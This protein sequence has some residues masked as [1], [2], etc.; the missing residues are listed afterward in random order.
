M[1]PRA[2]PSGCLHAKF[3]L[4]V[5]KHPLRVLAEFLKRPGADGRDGSSF[6][7][8]VRLGLN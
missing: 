1:Q 4:Q 6:S 7:V 5:C 8:W 2:K 3:G